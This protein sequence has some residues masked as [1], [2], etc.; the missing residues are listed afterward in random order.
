[1]I[2]LFL[3]ICFLFMLFLPSVVFQGASTGILLWF[4]TVFP[5]L[6]PFFIINALLLK[7]GTISRFSSILA[8][9]FQ[10][11]FHVSRGASYAILCG[12]FCGTPIGAKSI[13]S[14]VTEHKISK[15]EGEYLLSFCNNTS[16]GFIVSFLCS[17]TLQ[18]PKLSYISL[19]ILWCSAVL[20][21]FIFRQLYAPDTIHSSVSALSASFCDFTTGLDESIWESMEIIL[22]IGGYIVFFCVVLFLLKTIPCSSFL[23]NSI[24]LP[25]LELTNGVKMIAEQS[26]P[27]QIRY[28]LFMALASFGGF[29]AAFQTKCIIQAVGFSFSR[30]IK[31]KL[32][33]TMVT[34]LLSLLFLL[35]GMNNWI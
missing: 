9:F 21:S 3:V 13:V 17:Q 11:I 34:S 32:I 10:P 28:I 25:S 8:P 27:F 23:W 12:F 2:T 14:L 4:H 30:Y 15:E 18:M 29:C 6:F 5:T 19:G 16:P 33:T 24:F 20:S 1:M 22:K 35:S 31:E 26:L 7:T